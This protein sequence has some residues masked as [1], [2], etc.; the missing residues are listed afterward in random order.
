VTQSETTQRATRQ[1]RRRL[2]VDL[3]ITAAFTTVLM[4][5]VLRYLPLYDKSLVWIPDGVAQ[6]Y[7]TLYFL[8][9]WLRGMVYNPGAGVPLWSWHLGLG[10]DIIGVLSWHVVGDP[11]ALVSLL[12]P[13]RYMET[14]FALTYALR[15][16]AAALTS[17][18]YFRRMGAK[19]LPSAVGSVIYVFA[20]F[21]TYGALHHPFFFNG[22][23]FLPLLLIGAENV[24]ER[25]RSW[26]L[27]VFVAIA[28]MANYYFFYII[29]IVTALYAI[30][31][32]FQTAEKATRWRGLP[33]QA[34]RFAGYYITG[35]A[36]AAPILLPSAW[37]IANTARGQA[38][39][40]LTLFYNLWSYRSVVAS[41]GSSVVG[42]HSTF[43]GFGYLGLVLVP[44]FFV[45]RK[46]NGALK[47]MVVAFAFFVTL[48][49]FGS[50]FNGLTF[51]Y[52]RF[53][54]AWGIFIAAIA[55]LLLSEDRPFTR[56]EVRA[57]VLGY[58][59]YVALVL[60]FAQPWEPAAIGPMAF[61][62][63]TIAAFA[64]ESMGDGAVAWSQH[65]RHP[66][67]LPGR[68]RAP[69][70]RWAIIALLLGNVIVNGMYM[71]DIRYNETLR[72]YIDAGEVRKQYRGSRSSLIHE[73][74]EEGFYRV[75][76]SNTSSNPLTWRYY[77]TSLVEK[78]KGISYYFSIMNYIT[79]QGDTAFVPY[80][81]EQ[82][83]TRGKAIAF[84][85]A[86]ALPLGFVYTQAIERSDYEPLA[87][88][89]KQS[90]MLQ[91][92][93]VDDG[94]APGVSRIKPVADAIDLAYTVE[95]TRGATFDE[96]TNTIT[97]TQPKSRIELAVQERVPNAE[98]YVEMTGIEN[99]IQSPG[100]RP[101]MEIGA[102]A[103][104]IDQVKL[105]YRDRF[106]RQP[107][108]IVTKYSTEQGTKTST[109]RTKESQYYWGRTSQ[110]TNMGYDADGVTTVTIEP[111]LMG[112]LTFDSLKV[113]ALPMDEYPGRVAKLK[114]NA[115]RD[116]RLG[117][118][119]VSGTVD[120]PQD[121][122]LFLSIPYT[123]GW[124]AEV[125]GKPVDTLRVNTTYTG[126]PVSAGKHTVELTYMT[127][128]LI[129]GIAI[130]ALSG[131]VFVVVRLA[132]RWRS[133]RA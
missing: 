127:P 6:H 62:A 44:A 2:W 28:A 21:L 35:M 48:P 104:K 74:P 118:N 61:G 106:F 24:R 50:L 80:G 77:N 114:A 76:N 57:M 46:V 41:L 126:V 25:R 93:V 84:R 42:A 108:S 18:L 116:I 133:R 68:W 69:A 125:D 91:G 72:S 64:F 59:A 92:V 22:M 51:P 29:T 4:V 37:S 107:P 94:A 52:N 100:D 8:N 15:I 112:T 13:M 120:S 66:Q 16:V 71:L 98:V 60:V 88:V 23:V 78:Y 38:D 67:W 105:A 11:F 129:P 101:V 7:P 110:L 90:A 33:W 70:T 122:V 58:V 86:N 14:A 39:Y 34:L 123:P 43:L 40:Q 19:A 131:V 130:A 87:P 5:V 30:A 75:S 63:L 89:D 113:W 54:F 12:F 20:T 3:G 56:R 102:D 27:A 124:T 117:T 1:R 10:A 36:I 49:I 9:D 45:A 83:R 53:S 95:S 97:R 31:R 119:R 85:N 99:T 17:T 111:D 132:K 55:A 115:M 128:W 73:L 82:D 47:F 103:P 121:G 26:T 109:L 81:F 96:R 32:Y 79:R 65:R